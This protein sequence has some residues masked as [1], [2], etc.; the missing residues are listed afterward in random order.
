M[1]R[2]PFRIRYNVFSII[3][4]FLCSNRIGKN[5]YTDFFAVCRAKAA[6]AKMKGTVHFAEA[7]MLSFEK[8]TFAR[9]KARKTVRLLPCHG[10]KYEK[11]PQRGPFSKFCF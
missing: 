6:V 9:K 7:R 1:F 2:R 5:K 8:R 11:D 10:T 3:F 4:R